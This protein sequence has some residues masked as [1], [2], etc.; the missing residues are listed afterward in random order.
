MQNLL[1]KDIIE[2][3]TALQVEQIKMGAYVTGIFGPSVNA[4]NTGKSEL[5]INISIRKEQDEY[6]NP[7]THSINFWVPFIIDHRKIPKFYKGIKVS[8]ITILDT[9]PMELDFWD[10]EDVSFEEANDPQH[11]IDFVNRCEEEIKVKFNNQAMTK[12]EILDALA[13]GDFEKYTTNYENEKL[14]R[15]IK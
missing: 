2:N 13:F 6:V 4:G 9:L 10:N 1:V 3:F 8:T 14:K 7:F 5:C 12:K 11:Y 15:L